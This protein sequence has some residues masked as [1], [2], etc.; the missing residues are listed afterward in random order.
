MPHLLLKDLP[1]Y[2]C[3]LEAAL[4]RHNKFHQP[5]D[6]FQIPLVG[7]SFFFGVCSSADDGLM[8]SL[9]SLHG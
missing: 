4:L 2:E 5:S 6:S 7:C 3:L 8:D 1:R 9:M